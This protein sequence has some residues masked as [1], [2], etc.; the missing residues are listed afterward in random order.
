M[1]ALLTY[2]LVSAAWIKAVAAQ[3]QCTVVRSMYMAGM[4]FYSGPPDQGYTVYEVWL[5]CLLYPSKGNAFAMLAVS[6]DW[7]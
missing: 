6:V 3:G 5:V 4:D 2:A 1:N 7:R